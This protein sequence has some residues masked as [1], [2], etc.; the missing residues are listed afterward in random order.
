MFCYYLRGWLSGCCILNGLLQWPP[1][2]SPEP[3]HGDRQGSLVQITIKI[4]RFSSEGNFSAMQ[5][6]VPF[7][8]TSVLGIFCILKHIGPTSDYFRICFIAAAFAVWDF[9]LAI[10]SQV[11]HHVFT[12]VR[13]HGCALPLTSFICL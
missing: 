5:T 1:R 12:Y 6:E 11:A 3:M 4:W 8:F 7:V 10:L 2:T 9:P 13:G